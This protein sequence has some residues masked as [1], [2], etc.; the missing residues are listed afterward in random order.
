M[1]H[2]PACARLAWAQ[3]RPLPGFVLKSEDSLSS[4]EGGSMFQY[5]ERFLPLVGGYAVVEKQCH[6]MPVCW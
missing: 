3:A 2:T 5:R 4:D 1:K 6:I